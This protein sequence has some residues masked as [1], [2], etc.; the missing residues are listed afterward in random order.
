MIKSSDILRFINDKSIDLPRE[1][2][3]RIIEE[4]LNKP[5][6]EMDA[7]L[8]EYC[9]DALNEI[10]SNSTVEIKAERTSDSPKDNIITKP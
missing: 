10:E 3:E 4:E 8:I 1:E 9:L 6:N 5:E 7:D 2:L